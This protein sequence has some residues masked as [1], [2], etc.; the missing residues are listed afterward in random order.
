[1]QVQP[2]VQLEI[3]QL[4]SIDIKAILMLGCMI[5]TT[6]F[7]IMLQLRAHAAQWFRPGFAVVSHSFAV[8]SRWFGGGFAC[9]AAAFALRCT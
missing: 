3:A 1:M 5:G 6:F 2:D 7:S 8:V 4:I 9:F